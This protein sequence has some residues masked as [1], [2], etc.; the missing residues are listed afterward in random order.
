MEETL[1]FILVFGESAVQLP[2]VEVMI[3]MSAFL[4]GFIPKWSSGIRLYLVYSCI[5]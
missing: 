4:I 2:V 3:G 5:T 1:T